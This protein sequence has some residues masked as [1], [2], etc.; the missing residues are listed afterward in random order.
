VLAARFTHLTTREANRLSAGQARAAIAAAVL[1][2]LHVVVTRRQAWDPDIAAAGR[3]G[4]V[5]TETASA[6]A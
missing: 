6:A 4:C 5:A 3:T 2:Q 1:R